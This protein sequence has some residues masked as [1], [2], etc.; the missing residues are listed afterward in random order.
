MSLIRFK[1]LPAAKRALVAIAVLLDG[2]E[3]IAYLGCDAVLGNSLQRT[4]QE[5]AGFEPEL[6]MP[7]A[8]TLLREAIS[9]LENN[10]LGHR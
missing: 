6:R 3:A 8:G 4:A 1:G 2:R 10:S 5:I 7:L 9:E